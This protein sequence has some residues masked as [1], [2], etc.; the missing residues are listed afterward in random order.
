MSI[1]FDIKLT[2]KDMYRFNLHQAYSGFQGWFAF[3][4]AVICFVSAAV[5]FQEGFNTKIVFYLLFGVILLI[6]V[7][8]TLWLRSKQSL[9]AS[10]VLRGA[11]HY[12]ID[13]EG[14]HVTQ[15]EAEGTLPWDQ[16]YK[17]VSN[18]HNVLI[19]STRINAYIIPREQLLEKY[20][21]L[22]ELAKKQLPKYRV[23]M[24]CE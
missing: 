18:R 22:A 13:E 5:T 16:V 12:L 7:P 8:G 17:M 11:L 10:E 24:N 15:G 3:F 4:L 20:R 9:A 21:D 2:S 1:E 6:Y 23:K 14:I 19:Y